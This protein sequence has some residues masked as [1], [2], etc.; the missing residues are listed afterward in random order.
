MA[1]AG[2]RVVDRVAMYVARNTLGLGVLGA[3]VFSEVSQSTV[4]G[5]GNPLA[6][7]TEMD[8]L[9]IQAS[10]STLERGVRGQRA[11]LVLPRQPRLDPPVSALRVS[12]ALTR[13]I[14]RVR[15]ALAWRVARM[16]LTLLSRCAAG[17]GHAFQRPFLLV[18]PL[19]APVLEP[20]FLLSL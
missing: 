6:G 9:G 4:R 19:A 10:G 11:A 16:C 3:E 18:L 13:Q 15:N 8:K 14:S 12:F 7:M 2:L 17:A 1:I 20:L 5:D